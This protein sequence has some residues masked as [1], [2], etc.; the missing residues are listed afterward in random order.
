M[1]KKI[2]AYVITKG[3]APRM[4]TAKW[5][6]Q[7]AI[8]YEV[9]CN[10]DADC[11]TAAQ[12]FKRCKVFHSMQR[13][14]VAPGCVNKR[15]YILRE[16]VPTGQW[17]IGLDDNIQRIHVVHGNLYGN[18]RLDIKAKPPV[19]F[20]GWRDVYR[21]P[22]SPGMAIVTA[23]GLVMSCESRGTIYGGFASTE[24]PMFRQTKYGYRRFVKT[25]FYVLKKDMPDLQFGGDNYAHDSWMSAFVVAQY[26][27]VV[28][29][30]YVHPVHKMFEAGGLGNG[31]QRRPHLDK[32]LPRIV[33]QFPGLVDLAR[34]AN[35]ALRFVRT[36]DASVVAWQQQHG[37]PRDRCPRW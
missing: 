21:Q 33:A 28:V 31:A 5:L 7:A 6:D 8:E 20:P 25:K 29:N 3:H 35:S 13:A 30:N 11:D 26:G 18:E 24:N 32:I 10:T 2:K 19:E 12:V 27:G 17:Y 15:N 1:N 14:K 9:V 36:S 4:H 22:L 16:L 34:G 37:W 23:M